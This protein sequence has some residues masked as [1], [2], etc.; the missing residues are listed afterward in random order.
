[1]ATS[2]GSRMAFNKAHEAINRAGFSVGQAVLS[3]G[4]VRTE[5]TLVSGKTLYTFP[6]LANDS[7]QGTI[8]PTE[9]RLNLQDAL[10][11]SSLGIFLSNTT[12]SAQILQ[13]YNDPQT[14]TGGTSG[15]DA[16]ALGTVYNSWL[17]ITTN[18]RQ[19]V[20]S[21]DISRHY[22]VGT[23]Q[24]ASAAASSKTLVN[25]SNLS[26]DGFSPIEPGWV[27][28]G[29]K[30]NQITVTLPAGMTLSSSTAYKLVLVFRGHV[31]QNVTPVR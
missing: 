10:Y 30:N 31:A 1:M 7:S 11:C 14:F 29:S 6:I 4:Y 25:Q 19:I 9:Q 8:N 24:T 18:N 17:S 21:Y 5:Q 12:N 3:Q 22:L 23:S 13:T 26:S 27:L 15:A 2:L 16:A 28:V 20:P